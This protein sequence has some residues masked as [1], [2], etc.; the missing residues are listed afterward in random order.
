MI[1]QWNIKDES[2][3][4]IS[5]VAGSKYEATNQYLRMIK[6]GKIIEIVAG[7]IIKPRRMLKLDLPGNERKFEPV[8][9][10]KTKD[11]GPGPNKPCLCGSGRKYKKCCV[12]KDAKQ[13]SKTG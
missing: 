6:D 4:S 8:A 1:R 9:P 10:I 12:R 13:N 7:K 5:I 2:G 3:N 11:T